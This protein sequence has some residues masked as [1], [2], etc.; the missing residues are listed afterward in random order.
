MALTKIAL[1]SLFFF[2]CLFFSAATPL[3]G[4]SFDYPVPLNPK[5]G[6]YSTTSSPGTLYSPSIWVLNYTLPAPLNSKIPEVPP[7]LTPEEI[8]YTEIFKILWS[9]V[10]LD[11]QMFWQKAINHSGDLFLRGATVS[12]VAISSF[13]HTSLWVATQAWAWILLQ[14]IY[15]CSRLLVNNAMLVVTIAWLGLCTVCMAKLLHLAFGGFCVWIVVP[16]W[17]ALNFLLHLRSKN[18][19][20]VRKEKMVKGFGS[21]DMM[22]SPPKS[23]VLEVVHNNNEHAGYASCA[24]LANG[25]IALLTSYH[26]IEDAHAVT[27]R[28]S[29]HKIPLSEFKTIVSSEKGDLVLLSGPPNWNGLLS[30]KAVPVITMKNLAAGDARLFYLREG[31]WYSGVAKLQG[32][33]M[34]EGLNFVDVLSNTSPG[35][36]G[37]PYFIGNKIAGVHTGGCNVN[38]VNLMAAIPHLEGITASRYVFETTAPKGKIF[39]DALF[40][41][42]LE[43]FSREE[44]RYF[45][46]A[47]DK[48]HIPESSGSLNGKRGTVRGTNGAASTPVSKPEDGELME[49]IMERLVERINTSRIEDQAAN[50][51]AQKSKKKT[52]RSRRKTKG[53]AGGETKQTPSGS[54]SNPNTNGRNNQP[55]KRFQDSKPA[56]K[57]PN[58]TTQS[59]RSQVDGVKRSSPSTQKW[60]PKSQAS[61]GQSSGRKQN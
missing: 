37:T 13:V 7:V 49:R 1:Y 27:S 45:M 56:G 18:I 15:W 41:E 29:G 43:E 26:V 30:C 25:E 44:A 11:T 58:S 40:E 61:A 3:S 32:R 42:L 28:K 39:D 5:G 6:E 14:T 60:V 22:M 4:G 46:K 23:S 21:F 59:K 8:S 52:R 17:K 35:F 2:S 34:T 50:L 16:A 55:Q 10:S 51:I 57:S 48:S 24:L 12:R 53:Q 31:E 20:K 38:N 54:S 47:R 19:F 33:N 9:K 36:S